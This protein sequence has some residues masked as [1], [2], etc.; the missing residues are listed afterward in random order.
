MN[1]KSC[2]L[3]VLFAGVILLVSLLPGCGEESNDG[4]PKILYGDSICDECGMILSDE[5]YAAAT[6]IDGDRGNEPRVFDDFNCQKIYESKHPDLVIV[7]RWCHDHDSKAWLR[8]NDAW[9]VHSEQI[10]TPMASNIA[11]FSS[12]DAAEAF[13]EPMGVS[14]TDFQT[15]RSAD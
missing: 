5:R 4:P 12:A 1:T 13:A 8:M 10:H 6:I 7:D 3:S 15:M 9:F 2:V 14:P 11:A